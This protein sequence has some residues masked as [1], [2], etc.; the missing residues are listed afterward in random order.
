MHGDHSAGEPSATVVLWQ[1]QGVLMA[2][3]GVSAQVAMEML[4]RYAT[5]AEGRVLEV[6]RKIVDEAGRGC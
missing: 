6:C 5:A 3:Y 4:L 1:A 2:R